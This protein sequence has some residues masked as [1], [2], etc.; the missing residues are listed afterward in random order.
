MCIAIVVPKNLDVLGVV[1]LEE[2]IENAWPDN[3][4]GAGYAF[5]H[6]GKVEIKKGFFTAD[7][8]I[9]SLEHDLEAYKNTDFLV[10]L[11]WASVGEVNEENCHP[12]TTHDGKYAFI[13]N[14]TIYDMSYG[15]KGESDTLLFGDFISELPVNFIDNEGYTTLIEDYLGKNKVAFIKADGTTKVYCRK[16]WILNK[17]SNILY[18]NDYF[19]KE[20]KRKVVAKPAIKKVGMRC[21]SCNTILY[22]HDE[23]ESGLCYDCMYESHWKG[24]H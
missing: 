15:I 21:T 9:E 1:E 22:S 13:H 20:I 18:S 12:F 7:S 14:G 24:M 3:S 17:E 23:Q 4:D 6:M 16:N 8:L 10:H 5:A 2:S 19:K 11:R